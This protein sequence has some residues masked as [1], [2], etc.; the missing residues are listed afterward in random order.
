MEKN[1]LKGYYRKIQKNMVGARKEKEEYLRGL[2]KEIDDYIEIHPDCTLDDVYSNFGE[3]DHI[4][5]SF[6]SVSEEGA[7]KSAVK[8]RKRLAVFIVAAVLALVAVVSTYYIIAYI[9]TEEYRN[10]VFVETITVDDPTNSQYP[11]I[12]HSKARHY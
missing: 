7:V 3:P 10:G 4:A 5:D 11:Q 1:E 2:K 9:K 8:H 6:L 12:D